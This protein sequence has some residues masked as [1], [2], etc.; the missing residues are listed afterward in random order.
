M[1]IHTCEDGG[2][3]DAALTA[4]LLLPLSDSV[5]FGG[6]G[7]HIT[8]QKFGLQ[9]LRGSCIELTQ[10]FCQIINR[11]RSDVRPKI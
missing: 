6:E 5:M 10:T 11:A 8:V 3:N 7:L 9:K 1:E 2:W 4:G